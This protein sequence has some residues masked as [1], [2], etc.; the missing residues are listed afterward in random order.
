MPETAEYAREAG[1]NSCEAMILCPCCPGKMARGAQWSELPGIYSSRLD[2]GTQVARSTPVRAGRRVP[3]ILLDA[4]PP[5]TTRKT[6]LGACSSICATLAWTIPVTRHWRPSRAEGVLTRR[7]LPVRTEWDRLRN[8]EVV[9]VVQF[10]S[11]FRR[12]FKPCVRHFVFRV[13]AIPRILFEPKNER[14]RGSAAT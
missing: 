8:I 14:K 9:T 5:G 10:D 11:A 13:L 12:V 1:D 2:L 7:C 3:A 4:K 6:I